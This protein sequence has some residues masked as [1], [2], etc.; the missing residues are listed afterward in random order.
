MEG[1]FE[2][3]ASMRFNTC[4]SL[5]AQREC[6]EAREGNT[7][8][9]SLTGLMFTS[10]LKY[11]L[12]DD[13]QLEI[14]PGS[15]SPIYCTATIIRE[16]A[17][18]DGMYHYGACFSSISE[19]NLELLDESLWAERC[20][21]VVRKSEHTTRRCKEKAQFEKLLGTDAEGEQEPSFEED[22]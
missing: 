14:W 19:S 1:T 15:F 18:L 11:D 2:K 12:Q 10:S 22:R 3:R 13:V 5:Q 17:C 6:T 21:A 20:H 16:E 4:W 8:N 7:L 9:I